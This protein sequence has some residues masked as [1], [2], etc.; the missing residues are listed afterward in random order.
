MKGKFILTCCTTA[1]LP[2]DY[3]VEHEVPYLCF[4]FIMDG[5]EY[6]DDLGKSMPYAEFFQRMKNGAMP[7]SACVSSGQYEDCWKKYLEAG[8]DILHICLGTGISGTYNAAC[9]AR[10]HLSR[11][12]PERKLVVIDSL[13]G[14]GGYGLLVDAARQ[15]RDEGMSLDDTAAWVM[16]HRLDV[17]HWFFTMDLTHFIRGGR[18]SKVAGLFGT[19]MNICPLSTVDNEGKLALFSKHH[20]KKKAM[21]AVIDIMKRH[22]VDGTDYSGWCVIDEAACM[23]DAQTMKEM[24]EANFPKI[25]GHIMLT[26]FGTTIGV[27]TGPGTVAVYYFGTKRL[28]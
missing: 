25:K 26:S 22:A 15:R 28:D 6:D 1:D 13:C 16:E 27:H 5:K 7:T 11:K 8:Q 2:A 3:Y 18:M 9:V 14:S 12:Y 17:N 20:G 4:H 23:E 21:E 24:I 19:M 10:D